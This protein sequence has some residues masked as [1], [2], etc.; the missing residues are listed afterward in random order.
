VVHTRIDEGKATETG[1]NKNL[2]PHER[3]KANA[4][5]P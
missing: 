5:G 3:L 2:I 1:E 4:Q